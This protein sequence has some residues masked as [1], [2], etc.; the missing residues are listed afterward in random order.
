MMMKS[1]CNEIY[2]TSRARCG[3]PGRERPVRSDPEPVVCDNRT[4]A[5]R[6][7]LTLAVAAL[8]FLACTGFIYF[9]CLISATQIEISNLQTQIEKA[10]SENSRLEAIHTN[11]IDL[12]TIRLS[13][14]EL[15]MGYPSS[16]QIRYIDS[17]VLD[18]G[19]EDATSLQNN[20]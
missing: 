4:Q 16:E 18:S 6:T 3:S 17:A 7:L 10:R 11:A 19:G 8:V 15:G 20:E 14:Q 5:R 2:Q 9:K 1:H 13:A 12:D